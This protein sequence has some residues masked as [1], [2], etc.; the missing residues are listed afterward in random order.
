[1][2]CS[3]TKMPLHAVECVRGS[4][5][6]LPR[7]SPEIPL[8]KVLLLLCHEIV[9]CD[10][11]T[12]KR[13]RLI[14]NCKAKTQNTHTASSSSPQHPVPISPPTAPHTV[15]DLVVITFLPFFVV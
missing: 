8:E 15:L 11:Q 12:E 10:T 13:I 2:L 14:N 4:I 6:F 1:M 3:L 7:I 9:I 5:S